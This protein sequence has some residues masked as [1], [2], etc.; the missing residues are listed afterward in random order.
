MLI[1]YHNP[2]CSKSRQALA[3]LED[4]G[5]DFSIRRYLDEPLDPEEISHLVSIV[6]SDPGELVRTS[7]GAFKDSS[8][9][10]DSDVVEILLALPGVMQRPILS[11][12]EKAVIGRPPENILQLL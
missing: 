8:F 2:R 9:S 5:V 3:L 4:G 12:G 10:M 7:D 11:D 1:L 6:D